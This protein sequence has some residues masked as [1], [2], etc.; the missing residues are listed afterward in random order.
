MK[1]RLRRLFQTVVLCAV[2]LIELVPAAFSNSPYRIAIVLSRDAAPYRQALE[3]F[4]EA[5]DSSGREH[6]LHEFTVQGTPGGVALLIERV[7]Q[8]EPDL[9]LTIGS[10]ATYAIAERVSDVP[11]V[12]S[13]VLPSS[14]V[15]SLQDLKE[16]H[17]NLT[18]ASMEI[19]L[20]TQFQR[21]KTVLPDVRKV[22]V[23]YNPQVTGP[24]MENASQLAESLGLELILMPVGSEKEVV[25]RLDS[26]ALQADALWSVADSTVFSPNGLRQILLA[27]L[28]NRIPFV[29]LSPAFVKAGALLAFSVDYEDVGRQSGEQALRILSGET[30]AAVPITVPRSVALSLNMNT[31]KQIKVQIND[32]VRAKAELF[33]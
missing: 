25:E 21:M 29:G 26:L 11:V 31:A 6:K 4:E 8:L 15:D 23:L 9:I 33:F 14:G 7:R 30:P 18:G 20:E 24:M 28:R 13:L 1:G 16:A 12:F 27:T 3:G 2:V 10:S 32:T 17:G 19:P 5:L 22:G